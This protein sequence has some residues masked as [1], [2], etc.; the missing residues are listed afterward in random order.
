ML[1]DESDRTA[2]GN[3]RIAFGSIRK[4]A[5]GTLDVLPGLLCTAGSEEL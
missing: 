3:K 5:G 2:G 1:E 4:S